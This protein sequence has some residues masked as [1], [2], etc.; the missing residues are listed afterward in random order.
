MQYECN[1]RILMAG[2]AAERY[3]S[4]YKNRLLREGREH[5]TAM[6][7]AP[8]YRGKEHAYLARFLRVYQLPDGTLVDRFEVLNGGTGDTAESW[9]VFALQ[10]H[11]RDFTVDVPHAV[12]YRGRLPFAADAPCVAQTVVLLALSLLLCSLGTLQ[13]AAAAT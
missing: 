10:R 13:L 11:G 4:P 6:F 5:Y 3:G 7:N 2:A 8:P 9:R 1:F 12:Y